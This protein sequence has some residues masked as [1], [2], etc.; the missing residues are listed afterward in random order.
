[1]SRKWRPEYQTQ[2]PTAAGCIGAPGGWA[3]RLQGTVWSRE[4]A[5]VNGRQLR[6]PVT[7]ANKTAPREKAPGRFCVWGMCF[8]A[9]TG[10]YLFSASERHL[11]LL[12]ES[13]C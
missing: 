1:M 12:E 9:V 4:I 7:K 13:V 10:S 3:L 11:S 6:V 5:Q 2:S 8:A